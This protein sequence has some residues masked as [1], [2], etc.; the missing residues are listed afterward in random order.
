VRNGGVL[1]SEVQDDTP[2]VIIQR[3]HVAA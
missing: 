2:G 3:Y 1:D